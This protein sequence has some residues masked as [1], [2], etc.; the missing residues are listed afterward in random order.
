MT[1]WWVTGCGFTP[2]LRLIQRKSDP[3]I[4]FGAIAPNT[5]QDDIKNQD[6]S[7]LAYFN[8]L[9]SQFAS[10]MFLCGWEGL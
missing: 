8:G 3:S 7:T 10:A 9:K 2:A 6:R 1:P 4:V 5:A